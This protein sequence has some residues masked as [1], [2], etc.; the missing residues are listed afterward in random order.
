M[1]F[2][3][4][5]I[6]FGAPLPSK[7][8]DGTLPMR[9]GPLLRHGVWNSFMQHQQPGLAKA[10]LPTC[11]CDCCR[12]AR[13][14]PDE[15]HDGTGAFLKCAVNEAAGDGDELT[16][17]PGSD[18]SLTVSQ[19]SCPTTTGWKDGFCT[20]EGVDNVVLEASP[21]GEDYNNFCFYSCQPYTFALGDPCVTLSRNERP[22][23]QTDGGNGQDVGLAPSR[24]GGLG[25]GLDG[26]DDNPRMAGQGKAPPTPKPLLP[27]SPLHYLKPN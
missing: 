15:M 3:L 5:L 8:T 19:T 10:G 24:G 23:Q 17:E 20:L 4:A 6:L 2:L 9:Q 11:S 7:A 1:T 12:V 27:P 18:G 14:E 26:W 22:S 13:R 25:T 21:D 16:G